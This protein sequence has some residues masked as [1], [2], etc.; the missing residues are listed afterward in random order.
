MTKLTVALDARLVGQSMT[1]DTSYWEGLI[2]NLALVESDC[3]FLLFSNRNQPLEIPAKPNIEWVKLPSKHTRWW[4]LVK[5]P[6]MARKA[7]ANVLHTQYNL[8]PLVGRHGVT[9]IHD[10]SFFIG[11]QWFSPRDRMLLQMQIPA[12]VRR[13]ARV[14][15]VSETSRR[16]IEHF[17]PAAIGKIR[18]TPN[19]LGDNIRPMSQSDVN[20][21]LETLGLPKSYLLTVGT[22]WPRKNMRLAVGAAKLA[23]HRL[24]VVGKKG[25]GEDISGPL[26]TGYVTD[27]Q[28]TACYQGASL[29]LAP[30]LHEGFGIPLLEAFACGC[31]VICSSGGALPEV[32]GG[33]AEVM[34]TF[35]AQEWANQVQ[36]LLAD[37]SKLDEMR[38]KGLKRVNDFSW[39]TTAELTLD[40]Y[41]E[42][43]I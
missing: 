28:L 11:P 6:V 27:R 13:A 34:G 1:G 21:E 36:A 38:Q 9:T 19:A 7:G 26:Y 16:E 42:A 2:N 14:I 40:V 12:S 20:A 8:S 43:A 5:F 4:S 35:E 39:K 32:S 18:V 33:A 10:V 23:G 15:T 31:P 24:V 17:V 30:S 3:R 37:S 25:W 29:Y 41:R 22:R